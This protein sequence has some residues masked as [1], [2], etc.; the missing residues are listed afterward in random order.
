MSVALNPTVWHSS[1][2]FLFFSGHETVTHTYLAD[3]CL[4]RR[5]QKKGI[6]SVQCG[7]QV[8]SDA[9]SDENPGCENSSGK[10]MG[11]ARIVANVQ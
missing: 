9:L 2:V 5:I 4:A 10:R 7:A 8:Y 6:Q 11:K 3:R 1:C